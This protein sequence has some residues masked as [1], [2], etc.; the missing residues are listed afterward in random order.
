MPPPQRKRWTAQDDLQ[1]LEWLQQEKINV[2]LN[3][4][5]NAVELV[6]KESLY[7]PVIDYLNTLAWDGMLRADVWMIHYL[8]AADNGM[9]ALCR[10]AF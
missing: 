7:H 1:T 2:S 8:G 3:V 6:A 5:E 10:A 4:T 9:S